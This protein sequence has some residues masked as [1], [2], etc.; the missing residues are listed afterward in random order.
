MRTL[1]GSPLTLGRCGP[2]VYVRFPDSPLAT[3]LL[4]SKARGDEIEVR[5]DLA[6][7]LCLIV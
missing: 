5:T 7:F 4:A 6:V 2:Q 3:T 1:C